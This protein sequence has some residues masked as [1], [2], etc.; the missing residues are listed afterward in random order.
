MRRL[1]AGLCVTVVLL[2][3]CGASTPGSPADPLGSALSYVPLASPLTVE[4]QTGTHSEIAQALAVIDARFPIATLAQNAALAKLQTVGINYKADVRPLLGNP[5][6][7]SGTGGPVKNFGRHFLLAWVTR[8]AQHLSALLRKLHGVSR[9]GTHD[10]A[11]LYARSGSGAFAVD[12]AT[13]LVARSPADLTAALDR[14]AHGGGLTAAQH[15]ADVQG[16]DGQAAIQVFG[17]LQAVLNTPGAATAKRD[18][19]VGALR[20]YGVTMSFARSGLTLA[21]RLGTDPGSVTTA[22]LPLATGAASPGLVSGLP[23]QA[24]IHNPAHIINFLLDTIQAVSP[25]QY[26][27]V[28]RDLATAR[29]KTGIDLRALFSQLSGDMV[30]DSDT[31]T[32]L[33][34]ATVSDP[35]S[36]AAALTK[37]AAHARRSRPRRT[38]AAPRSRPLRPPGPPAARGA[39]AHR[40]HPGHRRPAPRRLA[41]HDGAEQLRPRPERSAGGRVGRRRLPDRAGSAA[42]AHRSTGL[43][44]ADRAPDPRPAR[45]P[46]RLG[47]GNHLGA[48]RP[49]DPRLPLI[50]V[51]SLRR[52]VSG[53]RARAS[54]PE[55]QGPRAWT[56]VR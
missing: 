21:F 37:L 54:G 11:T 40:Q 55:A 18:P 46:H 24:G 14:H 39:L 49:R 43:A 10:G 23:I 19:W 33:V 28:L 31:H 15:S 51:T 20:T 12:G 45:R 35:T 30:V 48:D 53:G 50:A 6:V 52:A 16:L 29:R 41:V 26:Q 17:D 42:R 4:V 56:A 47:L 22:E 38:A 44:V 34:R 27:R 1:I 8:S 36:V 25:H 13:L 5:M 3:G 7:F 9:T 32:T 2:A